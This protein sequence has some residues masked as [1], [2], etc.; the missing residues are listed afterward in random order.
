MSRCSSPRGTP[1]AFLRD[2]QADFRRSRPALIRATVR[3]AAPESETLLPCARE[4][5]SC[6][7]VRLHVPAMFAEEIA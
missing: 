7:A 1:A 6:V 2:V 5:W 4:P 3:T